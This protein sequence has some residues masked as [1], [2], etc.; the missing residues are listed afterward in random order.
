M[1]VARNP[2]RLLIAA[3]CFVIAAC[4]SRSV[5][6]SVGEGGDRVV[7]VDER[8]GTSVRVH[9]DGNSSRVVLAASADSVF[10]AVTSSYAML[11]VPVTYSDRASG[12]QGNRKFTVSRTFNNQPV[13]TWLNCGDDPFGGPNANSYPVTISLVTGAKASGGSSTVLETILSGYTYK[14]GGNTGQIYCASTGA[15]EQQIAKMVASR[16]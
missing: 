8:L 15:L 9:N 16:L 14:Q 6:T 12:V 2:A 1:H 13:A 11:R 5:G 10:A 7:A 3:I 4:A